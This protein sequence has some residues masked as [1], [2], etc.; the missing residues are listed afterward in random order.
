MRVPGGVAVYMWTGENF[1]GTPL[2]P[3][4]G[5][6]SVSVVDGGEPS[7]ENDKSQIKSL[8]IVRYNPLSDNSVK[9]KIAKGKI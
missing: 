3:Y 2:G 8:K 4:I 6:V 9:R 7:E 1:T 5:P